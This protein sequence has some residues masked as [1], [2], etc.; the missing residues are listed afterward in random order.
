M[1]KKIF[2]ALVAVLTWGIMASDIMAAEKITWGIHFKRN[3]YYGMPALAA[4]DQ[5]IWGKEGL[6]VE[7]VEFPSAVLLDR[8]YAAGSLE[9]GTSAIP[10]VVLSA[11]RGGAQVMVG[12]PKTSTRTVLWVLKDSPI[13]KPQDLKGTKIGLSRPGTILH[14]IAIGA[15]KKLGIEDQVKFLGLGGGRPAIAALRT[16]AVG[17][18]LFSDFTLLSLKAQGVAR[19][20]VDLSDILPGA[21]V[22]Q[23]LSAH[24]DYVKRK[25][26]AVK[27]AIRAYMKGAA[28]VLRNRDW[29]V[30]KMVSHH[31][32]SKEAANLAFDQFKYGSD[33]RIEVKKLEDTV[34]FMVDNGLVAKEKVPPIEKLYVAGLAD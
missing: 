14:V 29:S 24:R 12:D 33:A 5:G 2:T 7:V 27:R 20:G 8:A 10:S 22:P 30:R 6:E 11:S 32:W 15:M 18:I 28:F 4:D 19:I 3:P 21:E 16:G 26:E 34:R 25:A 17:S 23:A 1:A 9:A 31:K 13:R